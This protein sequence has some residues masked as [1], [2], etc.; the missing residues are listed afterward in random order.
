MNTI[1]FVVFVVVQTLFIPMAVLGMVL[2]CY[3]QIYISKQLGVPSTAIEVIKGR[4]LMHI[5]GLRK[6]QASVKLIS[7]L[8]NSS[9][10]GLWLVFLLFMTLRALTLGYIARRLNSSGGWFD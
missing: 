5:F 7:V 2:L 10:L 3:K 9:I 6:D 1:A 4:W 8:P